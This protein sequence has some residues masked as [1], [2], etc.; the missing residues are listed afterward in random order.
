[1]PSVIS[2]RRTS[3]SSTS[4][5]SDSSYTAVK[6]AN[7]LRVPVKRITTGPP[8]MSTDSVSYTA[9]VIWLDTKREYISLYSLYW[10]R[11]SDSF[12]ASGRRATSVGR[13]AS[14]ASCAV[15]R[16]LYTLG[17]SGRYSAP[18][19]SPIT[20]RT[21]ATASSDTRVESVRM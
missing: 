15:L 4:S 1:M 16:D 8:A 21:A 14:C 12:I 7:F 13:I 17:V 20:P 19:R 3:F 10:S 9:G 5:S 18:K 6:P 11:V 2:G